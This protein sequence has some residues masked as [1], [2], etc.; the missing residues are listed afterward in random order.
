MK[1]SY[2]QENQK[3]QKLK[4]KTGWKTLKMKYLKFMRFCLQKTRPNG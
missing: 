1:K 2:G 4:I 3:Q